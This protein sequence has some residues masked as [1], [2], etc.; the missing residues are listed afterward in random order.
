MPCSFVTI[1]LM[2][3]LA[4]RDL[5]LRDIALPTGEAL[6]AALDG[7]GHQFQ[8]VEPTEKNP[9]NHPDCNLC[10]PEWFLGA[11]RGQTPAIVVAAAPTVKQAVE[12][13]KR[14]AIDYLSVP[15]DAADLISAVERALCAKNHSESR[16]QFTIIGACDALTTIVARID[17]VAGDDRTVSILGEQGTGKEL[18]ARAI[19][20]ASSRRHTPMFSMNCATIPQEMLETELFGHHSESG[21]HTGLFEAASGG[22]L[23]LHEIAELTAEAQARLTRLLDAR[24]PSTDPAGIDVRVIAT[25]HRDLASMTEAGQFHDG[26]FRHL[27]I[28]VLHLPP[29][30]D[31]GDDAQLLADHFARKIAR[32]LRRP[33][34]AITPEARAI[35]RAYNWPGNVRELENAIERAVLVGNEEIRADDL[36]I[37]PPVPPA[38]AP[39]LPTGTSATSLEDYFVAFVLENQDQLTE[40]ELAERLG[41][42]RK[43]LWERRQRLNIPR[44]KTRKRAPR[45][46]SM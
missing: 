4:L 24:D 43:S 37:T 34:P 44:K 39:H 41:I 3:R 32:K 8:P 42:S 19:H 18:L 2:A 30:R 6:S 7:A 5:T 12:V 10:S 29:L 16:A 45:R 27:G 36:A 35:I 20:G 31:R 13:M 46:G 9:I 17:D 14:G 21:S 22:T 40:T 15:V 38:S 33:V 26:L 1:L 28:D 11:P 25:S 23:V